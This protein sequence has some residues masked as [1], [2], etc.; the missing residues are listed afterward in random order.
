MIS[1]TQVV[2]FGIIELIIGF[3]LGWFA[4]SP[5]RGI[6]GS[7]P[8]TELVVHPAA[9]SDAGPGQL[10]S[11]VANLVHQ[12]AKYV[13]TFQS[14]IQ[15]G[16]STAVLTTELAQLRDANRSLDDEVVGK[17]GQ[18]AD[19]AEP[20]LNDVAGS[21]NGYCEKTKSLDDLLGGVD[22]DASADQLKS[23][24]SDAMAD[25]LQSKQALE[26][27]L[28]D[29]RNKLQEQTEKLSAA[30]QDARIDTLTRL[31]NRR[32]FEE[33]VAAAHSLFE[34][35]QQ[36]Y[37]LLMFDVDHF[38]S[39][40]DTHG[41]AAGDTVLQT[42]ARV[43]SEKKRASDQSFRLGGEE[44]VMLLRSTNKSDA[45][46]AAERMRKAI[47]EM[48]VISDGKN[49]K[50][51]TS[52]GVAQVEMGLTPESLL[53]RADVALYAAKEGGRNRTH[54]HS[55]EPEANQE[56]NTAPADAEPVT[57]S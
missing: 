3:A 13:E 33:Q 5:R 17:V 2:I 32:S 22:A 28:S 37:S 21:V 36:V 10:L 7:G 49:L 23:M 1:F 55:D 43:L 25:V 26:A 15:Q 48:E 54:V 51:T 14:S 24:L 16:K 18:L 30:E 4:R 27:E 8:L 11:E 52:V 50:V 38:K 20:A 56:S 31:P 34:R 39:F 6:V 42:V 47:E 44:F 29:A 35:Q 46:K 53:E 19:A 41:H 12:H 40:N 57:A 9:A 45:H